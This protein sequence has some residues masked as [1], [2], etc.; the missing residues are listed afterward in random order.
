MMRYTPGRDNA[1]ANARLSDSEQYD[2]KRDE[3]DPHRHAERDRPGN[4]TSRCKVAAILVRTMWIFMIEKSC[5]IRPR[6]EH[7][8]RLTQRWVLTRSRVAGLVP[9]ASIEKRANI[10]IAMVGELNR[11]GASGCPCLIG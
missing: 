2:Q 7:R 9:P 3:K 11:S 8:S 5:I 10:R 6:F 4:S 1:S